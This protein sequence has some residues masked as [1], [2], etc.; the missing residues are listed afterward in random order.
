M[1]TANLFPASKVLKRTLCIVLIFLAGMMISPAWGQ[2]AGSSSAKEVDPIWE[3]TVN[4][5]ETLLAQALD[6][7][8]EGKIR[9]ASDA[10]VKVQFDNYKN[11]LLETAVRRFVSQ[12]KDY[13]NNAD[14]A[15]I[16]SNIR[17]KKPIEEIE[18]QMKG[19]VKELRK[20][21]VDLPII[22]GVASEKQIQ[23]AKTQKI[24]N[25]DWETVS[26]TFSNGLQK[27]LSLYKG[28]DTKLAC[29]IL[30]GLYIDVF[31]GS[32]ME[33]LMT[34]NNPEALKNFTSS[35]SELM[36]GM[37]N[38]ASFEEIEPI[39]A[40]MEKDFQVKS[41]SIQKGKSFLDIISSYKIPIGIAIIIILVIWRVSRKKK[42]E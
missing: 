1:T 23:K 24:I 21:I 27:M 26:L 10:V 18:I 12:Q 17:E 6:L 37:R 38:G 40:K 41:V 42:P 35:F 9:K 30:E 3:N 33:A 2:D 29:A 22:K 13:A 25:Q 20:D 32:G 16:A 8:K 5:I 15:R 14:F 36:E 39:A 19:L 28:G 11:T 31:E 34:K 7:Y 4:D